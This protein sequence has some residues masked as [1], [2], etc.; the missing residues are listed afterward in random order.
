MIPNGNRGQKFDTKKGQ[1]W[2]IFWPMAPGKVF[3]KPKDCRK[4]LQTRG[5]R[6]MPD[7][8]QPQRAGMK[9]PGPAHRILRRALGHFNVET[10]FASSE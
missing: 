8:R 5:L 4:S 6:K 7:L 1:G 10:L 9:F 3:L 2:K